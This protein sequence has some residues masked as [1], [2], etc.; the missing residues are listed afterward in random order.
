MRKALGLLFAASLLVPIGVITAS[1]AGSAPKGPTC[2]SLTATGAFK[3][4]LP[5]LGDP[6]KVNSHVKAVGKIGGCTGIPGVTSATTSDVYT[7]NGNCTTFA[8]GKGGVT[9]PGPAT[10]KWNKGAASTVTITT[11]TLSKPG[12]QPAIIQLTTKVTK[13]Q[14]KGTSN[15]TKVKGTAAKDACTKKPLGAFKLT[16]SGKSTF[17]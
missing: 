16:G 10:I 8:T 17:K 3:P 7:Y 6:K 1:P 14:F 5:K 15:V 9:K 4:A 12:V 2:T 13:G 11:K